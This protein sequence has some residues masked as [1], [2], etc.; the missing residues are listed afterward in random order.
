MELVQSKLVPIYFNENSP[1]GKLYLT[2]SNL[3]VNCS[4]LQI[5]VNG[6]WFTLFFWASLFTYIILYFFYIPSLTTI[7]PV[8]FQYDS[9]CHP[10]QVK[11]CRNPIAHVQLSHP[12]VPTVF[13]TGQSYLISLDFVAPESEINYDQGVFMV[14]LIFFDSQGREVLSS[15]RPVMLTYRS[16]P[17]RLMVTAVRSFPLVTGLMRETESI[18]LPLM[19]EFVDGAKPLIGPVA[20]AKLELECKYNFYFHVPF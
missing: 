10:T 12:K 17:V 19:E 3:F 8:H 7:R 2:L 16:Y 18:N 14:K 1:Q 20:Y 4:V 6:L 9:S 11:Q 15:S 13:V 5:I